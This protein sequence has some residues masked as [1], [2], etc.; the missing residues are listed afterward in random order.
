MQFA[1]IIILLVLPSSSVYTFCTLLYLSWGCF[2]TCICTKDCVTFFVQQFVLQSISKHTN[3]AY[4]WRDTTSIYTWYTSLVYCCIFCTL[5]PST[6]HLFDCC[7][8]IDRYHVKPK[9]PLISYDGVCLMAVLYTNA[10]DEWY[11]ITIDWWYGVEMAWLQPCRGR[12]NRD[13][14]TGAPYVMA[15]WRISFWHFSGYSGEWFA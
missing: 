14:L 7:I 5:H 15:R 10:S 11:I 1:V 2:V 13:M 4:I 3:V 8:F 12:C 6:H 9:H